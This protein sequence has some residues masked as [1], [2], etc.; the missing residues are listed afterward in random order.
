MDGDMG[1]SVSQHKI[2]PA[3]CTLMDASS[4]KV[5]EPDIVDVLKNSDRF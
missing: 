2:F 4:I 5:I 1:T 3:T